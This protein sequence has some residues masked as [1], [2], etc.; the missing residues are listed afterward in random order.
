MCPLTVFLQSVR[1]T[2]CCA[3]GVGVLSTPFF[4][5]CHGVVLLV[6]GQAHVP[7][8]PKIRGRI[9]INCEYRNWGGDVDNLG[10]LGWLFWHIIYAFFVARSLHLI[11]S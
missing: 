1:Q 2:I 5:K 7:R 3:P 11:T 9:V 8:V 10:L 4:P 6:V